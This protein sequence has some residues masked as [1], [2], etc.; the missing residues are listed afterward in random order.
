MNLFCQLFTKT[1]INNGFIIQRGYL[2]NTGSTK[3]Q[4]NFPI[5]FPRSRYSV[6]GCDVGS[7]RFSFA[8]STINSTS[9]Y[10][11]KPTELSGTAY[12]AIGY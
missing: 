8:F 11:Y 12:I 3:I 6:V 2:S 10:W 1:L 4:C 9:F 7:A 5:A